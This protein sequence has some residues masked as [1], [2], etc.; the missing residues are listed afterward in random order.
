MIFL[1]EYVNTQLLSPGSGKTFTMIGKGAGENRGLYLQAAT[2]IYQRLDR[3]QKVVV[4]FF[5]IYSG[6]LYDLLCDRKLLC[7]REDGKKIVNVVG[8]SEH[9][10]AD[11]NNLMRLIEIGNVVR[12]SGETGANK[13]SSRSHAILQ[14]SCVHVCWYFTALGDASFTF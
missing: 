8:L 11:V 13:E 14:V 2:D 9:H 5:E 3:T 4:S 7:A 6:K 1:V 12:A 10:V